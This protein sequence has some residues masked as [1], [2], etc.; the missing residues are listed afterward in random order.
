MTDPD[1]TPKAREKLVNVPNTQDRSIFLQ[2][3]RHHRICD[4]EPGAQ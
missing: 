3:A 1:G 4:K 2:S